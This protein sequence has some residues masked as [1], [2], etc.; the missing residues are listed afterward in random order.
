VDATSD[1]LKLWRA[2]QHAPRRRDNEAD[3]FRWKWMANG[4]FSSKTAYNMLFHGMTALP[5]TTNVWHSFAPLK[6]KLHAWLGLRRRSWTADR[7]QQRGL[8]THIMCPLCNTERDTLDHISLQCP[9]AI[10]VWTGVVSRLSLPDI[11]LSV[12]AVISEWWPAAARFIVW[13]GRLQTP[14]S[15]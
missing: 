9:F 15:C 1:Y 5:G 4:V 8:V 2:I 10:A 3:S 12:Q 14:L 6:F 11:S 7:P 13:I